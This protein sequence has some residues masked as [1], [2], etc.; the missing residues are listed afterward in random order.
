MMSFISFWVCSNAEWP[1]QGGESW[2]QSLRAKHARS[3]RFGA[4]IHPQGYEKRASAFNARAREGPL[5][6]NLSAAP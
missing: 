6:P 4:G 3:V 1:T 5:R 2:A